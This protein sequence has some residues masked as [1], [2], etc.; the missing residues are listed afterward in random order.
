MLRNFLW[1]TVL[2]RRCSYYTTLMVQNLAYMRP[3]NEL[4][5]DEFKLAKYGLIHNMRKLKQPIDKLDQ[6]TDDWFSKIE[7]LLDFAANGRQW[8]ANGTNEQKRHLLQLLGPNLTLQN[9][10]LRIEAL[11]PI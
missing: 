9:Q 1:D 10:K 11:K 3:N 4:D 8:F 7:E 6:W 5:A 2:R